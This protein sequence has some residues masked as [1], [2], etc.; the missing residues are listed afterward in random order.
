MTNWMYD[1]FDQRLSTVV[2]HS[3]D[4]LFSLNGLDPGVSNTGVV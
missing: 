3:Y 1:I 2:D 4:E